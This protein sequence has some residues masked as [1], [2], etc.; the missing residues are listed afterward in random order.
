MEEVVEAEAEEAEASDVEEVVEEA[1]EEDPPDSAL[2][3][4]KAPALIASAVTISV[5][6]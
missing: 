6:P 2:P 4:T 5:T 1:E 3:T